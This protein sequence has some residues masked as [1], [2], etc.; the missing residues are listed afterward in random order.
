MVQVPIVV[1]GKAMDMVAYRYLPDSEST[2]LPLVLFSHGRPPKEQIGSLV[3]ID[4]ATAEWWASQGLAV[5]API[6]PGYGATG[7]PDREQA[8]TQGYGLACTCESHDDVRIAVAQFAVFAALSWARAQPW[9]QRD[10]VL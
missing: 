4:D 8:Y 3:P 1:H 7:G 5:L 10:H 9:V 6:R 2:A